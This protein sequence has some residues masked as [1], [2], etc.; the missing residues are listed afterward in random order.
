MTV[1]SDPMVGALTRLVDKNNKDYFYV[2]NDGH[3]VHGQ[4]IPIPGDLFSIALE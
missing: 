3:K 2:N 1:Y 4:Y